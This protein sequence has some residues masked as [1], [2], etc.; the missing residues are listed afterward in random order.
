[1]NKLQ[2]KDQETGKVYSFETAG[3]N[4]KNSFRD[5]ELVLSEVDT[6]ESD[7]ILVLQSNY[8][9]LGVTLKGNILMQE[10][11]ARAANFS[12]KNAEMNDIDAGI[13]NRPVEDLEEKFDK[14]FYAPA[15]YQPVE[16]VKKRLS[17]ASRLLKENGE[18]FISGKKKSGL[19]RYRNF[20]EKYGELEKISSGKV[21]A[22]RFEREEELPEIDIEKAFSAELKDEEADFRS[23]E[24]LF[25]AGNLDDGTRI[26]LENLEDIQG[27]V[28]DAACG[29]GAIGVFT[30]KLFDVEILMTDD[31]VCATKHAEENMERNG[32]EGEVRTGDCLDAFEDERF[33]FIISNPPTHQGK[34]VTQKIFR[35]AHQVLND[36]GEFWLV[37]NQNMQYEKQLRERFDSVEIIAEEDNFLVVKAEKF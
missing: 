4:S 12:R 37:Y 15:N 1:M 24:G 8:G 25:S 26:L 36:G 28:L 18:I 20:L 34:G 10:T 21:R 14:I 3:L 16:L 6:E 35:Q 32:V 31:N 13:E 11:S 22:Y 5:E 7:D 9:I 23:E 30:G 17:D 19:K 2:L 33:D 29:Y 27:K